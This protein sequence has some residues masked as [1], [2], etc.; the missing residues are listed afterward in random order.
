MSNAFLRE[1]SYANALFNQWLSLAGQLVSGARNRDAR[2][3][4]L[5]DASAPELLFDR[6]SFCCYFG[7][8]GVGCLAPR[9]GGPEP[10]RARI[11]ARLMGRP[12]GALRGALRCRSR[13]ARCRSAARGAARERP[14]ARRPQLS[15]RVPLLQALARRTAGGPAAR[16]S[17]RRRERVGVDFFCRCCRRQHTE[18]HGA[19]YMCSVLESAAAA[20]ARARNVPAP[21]VP[22]RSSL[23]PPTHW[24]HVLLRT[25]LFHV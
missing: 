12:A 19:L 5:V 21:R 25:A 3:A 22:A 15:L 14:A 18:T 10:A 13:R 2:S 23:E 24:R 9:V 11:H 1:A 7:A 6:S 16:R 4:R 20:R 8:R 17:W